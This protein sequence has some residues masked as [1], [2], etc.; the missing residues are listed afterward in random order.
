[1]Q[2]DHIINSEYLADQQNKRIECPACSPH[3]KKKN[4]KTLSLTRDS[5][6]ILYQ[7]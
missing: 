1:M 2:L 6:K 7:C 5:D 3:R 4:Q